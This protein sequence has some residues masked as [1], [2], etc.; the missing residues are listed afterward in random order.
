MKKF[1]FALLSPVLLTA[2]AG[3]PVRACAACYNVNA[4][5]KMGNAANWGVIA[6]AII[7]FIM[8]GVIA[9]AG[10]YLNWRAK[11]PLPDYSELLTEDEDDGT[12]PLPDAS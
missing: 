7:M 1:S 6:M 10:F 9:A 11:N 12:Q 4:G 3:L 8:L 5:S 2:V